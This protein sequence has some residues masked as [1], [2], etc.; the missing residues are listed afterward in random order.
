MSE[1]KPYIGAFWGARTQTFGEFVTHSREFL[2]TLREFVPNLENLYVLGDRMSDEKPLGAELEHFEELALERAW[3]KDTPKDWF[4]HLDSEGQPTAASTSEVGW[5]FD[6]VSEPEAGRTKN[7]TVVSLQTGS[8]TQILN[9]NSVSVSV[10]DYQAPLLDPAVSDRVFRY[11]VDFWDA[12]RA[13]FTEQRF[14]GAV[15]DDI[16]REQLGWLNYRADA[17]FARFLPQAVP[18][19]PHNGGVLFRLGDGRVLRENDQREVA[20]GLEIQAAIR[21]AN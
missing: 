16:T 1:F 21:A 18:R 2:L 5:G 10:R 17:N 7:Y 15:R 8:L 9:A 6:I 11:M 14:R 19:E 3:S 4:T 12:D 20:A 13:L